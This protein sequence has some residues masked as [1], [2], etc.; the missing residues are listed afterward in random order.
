MR[1][2]ATQKRLGMQ[3][4]GSRAHADRRRWEI[5][6]DPA[7]FAADAAKEA[8]GMTVFEDYGMERVRGAR[9]VAVSTCTPGPQ[10]SDGFRAWRQATG[11]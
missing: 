9:R 1:R 2:C 6:S 5:V 4:Q 3:V 7:Q 11:R 8:S 10:R